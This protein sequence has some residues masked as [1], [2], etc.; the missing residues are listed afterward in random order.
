[1][2]SKNI[3]GYSTRNERLNNVFALQ[4]SL[5]LTLFFCNELFLFNSVNTFY[6]G[7]HKLRISYSCAFKV[8][9]NKPVYQKLRMA[10][11]TFKT[12]ALNGVIPGVKYSNW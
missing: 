6:D 11:R 10:R 2:L 3:M 9:H 5:K 8:Y 12:L 4:E 7:K 1:M